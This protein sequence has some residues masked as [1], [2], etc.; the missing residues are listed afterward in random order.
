LTQKGNNM[1]EMWPKH[2][3]KGNTRKNVA[4]TRTKCVAYCIRL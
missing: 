3:R 1:R 2:W 4:K